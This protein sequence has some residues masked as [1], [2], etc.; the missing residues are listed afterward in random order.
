VIYRNVAAYLSARCL[1]RVLAGRPVFADLD[2]SDPP[3]IL[4]QAHREWAA[5]VTA[6]ATDPKLYDFDVRSL[7]IGVEAFRQSKP[8]RKLRESLIL[9]APLP[10][11]ITST[12][13]VFMNLRGPLVAKLA[14]DLTRRKVVTIDRAR[15][16]L[17]VPT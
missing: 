5:T 12:G 8:A 1:H 9:F 14:R 13:R 3:A 16:L 11:H 4:A 7:L 10:E 6:Y 15:E 17:R 2:C